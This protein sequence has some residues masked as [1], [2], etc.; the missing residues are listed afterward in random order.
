[1][2]FGLKVLVIWCNVQHV[3][4]YPYLLKKKKKNL[5]SPNVFDAQNS[6]IYETEMWKNTKVTHDIIPFHS[7]YIL[8]TGIYFGKTKQIMDYKLILFI[9]TQSLICWN[10][11][12]K[13]CRNFDFFLVSKMYLKN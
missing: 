3:I 11:H 12:Y 10:A 13:S 7:K 6:I 2:N 5:K 9:L 8:T 1:M 4:K